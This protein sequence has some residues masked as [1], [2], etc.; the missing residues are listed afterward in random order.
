MLT[1]PEPALTW[2]EQVILNFFRQL[3]LAALGQEVK[4]THRGRV[5]PDDPVPSPGEDFERSVLGEL[6][7]V[8]VLLERESL[9]STV[10]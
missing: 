2:S 6:V 5:L 7:V 3:D 1:R 9:S 8:T 10:T 4:D